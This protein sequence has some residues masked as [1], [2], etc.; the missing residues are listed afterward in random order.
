MVQVFLPK[1]AILGS[2]IGS[3]EVD[4]KNGRKTEIVWIL[5]IDEL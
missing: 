2:H 1:V 4:F 5:I 3:W